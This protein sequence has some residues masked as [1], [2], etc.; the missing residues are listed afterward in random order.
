VY[1]ELAPD[2]ASTGGAG[3]DNTHLRRL[4]ASG[5]FSSVQSITY[6]AD[7]AWPID[8]WIGNLG[9]QSNH[10]LLGDRL[11]GLLA[12]LRAALLRRGAVVRVSG[13]TYVIRASV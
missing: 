6:P 12:A 11:P 2:V 8:E 1:R 7:R 9:T 5:C 3:D 10:V 13:G 4:R